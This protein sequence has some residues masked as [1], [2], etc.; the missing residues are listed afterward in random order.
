MTILNCSDCGGIHYG[1][2][3]CPYTALPCAVC[4]IATIY[5]CSDCAIDS[6][7][8][9]SVHV[10]EKSE[11]RD[12]HERNMHNATTPKGMP[13]PIPCPYCG[14]DPWYGAAHSLDCPIL[15]TAVPQEHP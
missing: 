11:C 12:A 8:A 2:V 10:C 14:T 1:S 7:G 3:K 6:G 9:T 4:G 5:A 13:E 15:N